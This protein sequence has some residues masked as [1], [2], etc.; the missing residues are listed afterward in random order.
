MHYIDGWLNAKMDAYQRKIPINK[1][2]GIKLWPDKFNATQ[3]NATCVLERNEDSQR[4]M[5]VCEEHLFIY[6]YL[7]V[8]QSSSFNALMLQSFQEFLICT[9]DIYQKVSE[10][11]GH[12]S[13]SHYACS[14]YPYCM[15]VNVCLCVLCWE[16]NINFWFNATVTSLP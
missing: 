9:F 14:Q 7:W 10:F 1:W 16:K 13:F 5:R 8:D 12:S 3:S 2:C 6:I 4:Q 11:F 15:C